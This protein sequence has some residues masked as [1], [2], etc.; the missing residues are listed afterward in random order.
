MSEVP[1]QHM[2]RLGVLLY[3][4]TNF[5][6]LE[7]S[8]S[9]ARL[10]EL[11]SAGW[12]SIRRTDVLETELAEATELPAG[13]AQQA[14][15]MVESL[16]P[17]VVGHSRVEAMVVGG[18]EDSVLLERVAKAVFPNH[19]LAGLRSHRRHFRDV[20]HIAW[21]IRYGGD[22]FITEERRLLKRAGSL[23]IGVWT[24][25]QALAIVERRLTR[26][27]ARTT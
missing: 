16:G 21:A 12:I 14:M 18:D 15:A 22:A 27:Q 13:L 24:P 1:L 20:M 3:V 10:W 19:G 9:R 23:D 11:H 2:N 6:P 25:D 26:H 8:P 7:R 17:G 5:L 4:D